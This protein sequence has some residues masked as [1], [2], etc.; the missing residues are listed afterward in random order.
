MPPKNLQRI[1][2]VDLA[3]QRGA[4]IAGY[5]LV[6]TLIVAALIAV[7]SAMA[8][9]QLIAERRMSRSIVVTREIMTQ[10]RNTREWAMAQRQ[11]FTFQYNN[12][13]KEISIIDHNNNAGATLFADPAYPNNVGSRVVST[14][15]LATGGLSAAEIIYGIPAGLPSAPLADGT[16]MT[17][18]TNDRINITFQPDG[19]VIDAAGNPVG[20][21]LFIYNSSSSVA[22][23]S[24]MSVIGASGQVKSWR[25]NQSANL[26]AE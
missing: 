25:Y 21:A 7:V 8:V 26:Y 14:V 13:T 15:P 2:L 17:A 16:T 6:E 12:A 4:N 3:T 9:P 19:S 18:L 11:A 24:A 20:R 10:M 22:T 1:D 23:A 5:S